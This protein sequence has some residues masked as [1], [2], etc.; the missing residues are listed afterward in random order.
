MAWI[1][2]KGAKK[3]RHK[4]TVKEAY[5]L[6]CTK[7]EGV[8]IRRKPN[9]GPVDFAGMAGLKRSDLREQIKEISQQYIALRY[10]G[11]QANVSRQSL[12]KRVRKFDPK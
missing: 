9:Q 1:Q 6:F 4:D 7:L 10:M 8:G 11:R 3:A 2:F 5:D 12:L